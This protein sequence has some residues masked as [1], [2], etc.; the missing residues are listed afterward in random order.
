MIIGP[1]DERSSLQAIA[2][3][4][5]KGYRLLLDRRDPTLE[6]ALDTIFG[7]LASVDVL[8]G[9]LGDPVVRSLLDTPLE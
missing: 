7:A 2:I 9:G 4:L 5:A 6:P 1:G 3:Q 8:A